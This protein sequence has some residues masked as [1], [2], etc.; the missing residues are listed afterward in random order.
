MLHATSWRETSLIVQLITRDYGIISAVAKGA[1]RP[2]SVLR[3]VLNAFQPLSVSWSGGGEVKTLIS[4]EPYG[5]L[6]MRGQSFMSAW[7]MNEL[8]LNL[9]ARE[10][11]HPELFDAYMQ[12]LKELAEQQDNPGKRAYSPALRQ[13]EWVL[14]KE[15]GY[16]LDGD[17]P[18]FND[19]GIERSVR[20]KIRDRIDAIISRPLRTRQVMRDLMRVDSNTP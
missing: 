17:M 7:Y 5:I 2:N 11:P 16:G 9:L 14:L 3:P 8:I 12:A 1:K 4:A 18:D 6:A 13:F 10:D 19:H 15:T 20:H